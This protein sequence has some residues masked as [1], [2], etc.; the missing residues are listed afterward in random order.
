MW[1]LVCLCFCDWN[2]VYF[3]SS[4]L[5][6][7]KWQEISVFPETGIGGL[8]RTQTP[9]HVWDTDAVTWSER[10]FLF[11]MLVLFFAGGEIVRRRRGPRAFARYRVAWL[12]F[13][14]ISLLS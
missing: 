2:C 14:C 13:W 1:W 10:I 8:D 7:I 4:K 9:A 11:V 5:V 6:G 12:V 3:K